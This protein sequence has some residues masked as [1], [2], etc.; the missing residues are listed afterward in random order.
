[1]LRRI[2][3]IRKLTRYYEQRKTAAIAELERLRAASVAAE[4]RL[5]TEAARREA[6]YVRAASTIAGRIDTAALGALDA[7]I[8]YCMER[9]DERRRELAAS[10]EREDAQ[11]AR[12]VEASMTHRVW[13][14][15]FARSVDRHRRA[16]EGRRDRMLDDL[17]VL[18]ARSR[19]EKR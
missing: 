3:R 11:R 17:A 14:N 15:L 18:R 16:E 8:A 6:Y 1:M 4:R 10:R 2:K 13:E 19:T 12:V 9:A 5:S 7:G